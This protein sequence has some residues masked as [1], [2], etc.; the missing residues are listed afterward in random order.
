VYDK[1]EAIIPLAVGW[2]TILANY[3]QS[4]VELAPYVVVKQSIVF[5][6]HVFF[7]LTIRSEF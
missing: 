3:C 6:I 5:W 4:I 1:D 7:S 2:N